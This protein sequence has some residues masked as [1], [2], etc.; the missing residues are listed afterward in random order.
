V[1]P[2]AWWLIACCALVYLMVVVG[3]ITRLTESGLSITEW[4]PIAGVIPP[5]DAAQW[6]AE[7]DRYKAIPQYRAIHPD[8]TLAQFKTI[9]YWEYFH[10]LLG[11]VIG[12]AFF[13]PFAWF[14]V[15]GRIKGPLVPKLAGIFALGAIQGGIGWYMVESGL[16]HRI[17]V[18]QYRLALHL[19][20]AVVI[21]A[22]ML[23]VALDLL[24]PA[25]RR[26]G[27]RDDVR[28]M[29]HGATAVLAL[30]FVTLIAGAFVAGLRAGY[31]D[32]TFPLMEGHIVPPGYFHLVPWYRN[33][34]A[35][36]A[37]VQFDH[38]VLAETTF[39]A[40]GALWLYARGAA[41]TRGQRRAL[42]ALLA[43]AAVQVG[44]GIATLLLV[45]PLPL[46]ALHQAGAIG[47]IT[48]ALV[49]RHG[50][51]APARL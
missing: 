36:L 33:F 8:M 39:L 23:W 14:L 21:Y 7:F 42:D 24:Q 25:A 41:L 44:L 10:R 13:V 49:A 17:E 40:I 16:S 27:A 12:L 28:R 3:G 9:F 34:F 5:H 37:A 50:L 51:G 22:A 18:S 20:T 47:V 31:I 38:R 48:A 46:A 19:A 1:Q 6:T 43:M 26:A 30:A 29:R 11:R 4:Q 35:N 15:R 32:N 45:V 2:I